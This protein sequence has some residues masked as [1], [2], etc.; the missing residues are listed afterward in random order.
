MSSTKHPQL[1]LTKPAFVCLTDD[2]LVFLDLHNDK[3]SCLEKRYTK[4][5]A[6]LLGLPAPPMDS[7]I[8]ENFV[9][10]KVQNIAEVVQGLIDSEIATRDPK[11]GKPAEF[12]TQYSE[13]KELLGYEIGKA[14]KIHAGHLFNFFR[15]LIVTKSI[16]LFASMEHIVAR[17]RRRKARY[18]AKGGA[19][20][21][22][23]QVNELVEIYKILKPLFV[24]VK[25]ECLFNSLF[26][27]EFL[28]CYRIYPN[29]YFGVRLNEFYAHCWVQG[30]NVIYDDFIQSTCQ[31]QP[32]MTV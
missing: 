20:P 14:P 22:A 5:V 2:T 21:N 28:A 6:N 7:L 30:D 23:E 1:L 24:T 15:A 19:E 32:I 29:W 13:L 9:D 18:F 17:V 31:N 4:P 3:Y 16:L 10:E 8:P 27:I 11:L 25:D 26:L 12:I